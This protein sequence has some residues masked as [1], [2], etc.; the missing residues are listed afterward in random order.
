MNIEALTAVLDQTIA[1]VA[2]REFSLLSEG[3]TKEEWTGKVNQSL[4]S[5]GGLQQ[6]NPPNYDDPWI[7][8][9]YLTWYQPGQV[10][11]VL[12][13]IEEQ[14]KARGGDRLLRHDRRILHV[15]DFGCGALAMRFGLVL[16]LAEALEQGEDIREVHIDSI[17]PNTAMVQMG[18][19]VW[20]EFLS[21]V[22]TARKDDPRLEW[23]IAAFRTLSK[24]VPLVQNI[25]LKE[26][27]I[28]ED[29]DSWLT[30]IHAVY[31][32]NVE[33]VK[34]SLANLVSTT[35]PDVGILTG[36]NHA[37]QGP[38][39]Q[40]ASPFENAQF[41]R[42]ISYLSPKISY[43]LPEVTHWRQLLNNLMTSGHRYLDGQVT[44]AFR[45]SVAWVYS[46]SI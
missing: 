15:I 35:K 40:S 22:L 43:F 39:L 46:K 17:D 27:E 6:S 36:H 10:Q 21:Q 45:N 4:N 25:K 33:E 5:L 44:W 41:V 29:A 16:A 1:K 19:K 7:A 2:A 38:L 12:S 3:M 11:L 9:F 18:V 31:P 20:N 37:G 26:L 30:A 14:R 24:P 34:S 23:V 42:R 32:N 28:N 8:L 13:L